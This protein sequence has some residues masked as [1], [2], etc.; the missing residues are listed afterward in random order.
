MKILE[1]AF[2]VAL[3]ANQ[4]VAAADR[5]VQ[6]GRKGIDAPGQNKQ[7]YVGYLPVNL[8]FSLLDRSSIGKIRF[9]NP[10]IPQ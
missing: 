3:V 10:S 1:D 8:K 6:F 2:D 7:Q 9:Y 5:I 4:S